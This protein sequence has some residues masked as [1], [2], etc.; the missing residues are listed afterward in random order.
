MPWISMWPVDAGLPQ[1]VTIGDQICQRCILGPD[2]EDKTKASRVVHVAPWRLENSEL[3]ISRVV[4]PRSVL[5]TESQLLRLSRLGGCPNKAVP[6]R[7]LLMGWT[8]INGPDK[9]C[10]LAIERHSN[11]PR[12]VFTEEGISQTFTGSDEYGQFSTVLRGLSGY[13]GLLAVHRQQ[14]TVGD[15]VD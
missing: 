13:S 1:S 4:V 11:L 3:W 14:G 12:H 10:P 6:K 15:P 5:T 8:L 2:V 7:L 9:M